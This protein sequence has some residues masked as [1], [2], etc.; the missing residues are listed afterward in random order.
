MPSAASFIKRIIMKNSR[1]MHLY[2]IGTI[3]LWAT[4]FPFTRIVGKSMDPIPLGTIRC[5]A[6]AVFLIIAGLIS[7]IRLPKNFKDGFLLALA[8]AC[9]FGF[10]MIFFNTGIMTL[11]SATSSIVIA[12]TPV[13]TALAASHIYSE[14][15]TGI[16][17][18]AI[19]CAF[20][21]VGVLLLW[22]GT[23]SINV[24]VIWTLGA[25]VLFCCYN[26]LNRKLQA[27]G[28]TSME[29]M[30]YAMISA[31]VILIIAAPS[32][33]SEFA[34]IRTTDKILTVYMGIVVSAI[35]YF[36]WAK[37]FEH[38][39]HTSDVTN[40]MFLTPLVTTVL[41]FLMLHEV[42][43]FGTVVGGIMI[44]SSV[45]VFNLKGKAD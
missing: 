31:A 11:T 30:T 39:R 25:A 40:Y 16:G 45:I 32:A 21:G 34:G 20:I 14:K 28:Y 15:L 6:A 29:I 35:A 9:G 13:M 7:R 4:A 33:F 10:Y 24:G 3:L 1:V 18:A 37:A 23:L 5:T 22:S 8:G 17:Y 27:E 42:P 43:D 12:T 19:F 36:L 26:L 44:I 41:G 2:A 38:A